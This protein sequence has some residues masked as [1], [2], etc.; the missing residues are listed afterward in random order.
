MEATIHAFQDLLHFPGVCTVV[1]DQIRFIAYDV[2]AYPP[3]ASEKKN[4]L[5]SSAQV[6]LICSI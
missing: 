6:S 5:I 1:I 3:L 4:I 2:H